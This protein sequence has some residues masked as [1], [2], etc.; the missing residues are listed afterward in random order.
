VTNEN[1]EFWVGIDWA[2]SSH[3][4]CVL[5]SAGRVLEER[6]IDHSCAAIARL[7][8]DLVARAGGNPAKV[9][10]AIE[11]PH[12][13]VVSMLIER[14][15]AVFAINPK[16]LDRFRDRHSVAGAKDDRRDALVL[17]TSLRTDMKSFRRVRLGQA[18]LVQLRELVRVHEDLKH[19]FN[20]LANRLDDLL[21]RFYPQILKLG[22]VHTDPWLWDLLEL[23]P[24]PTQGALLTDASLRDLL[25][26][27]HIRRLNSKVVAEALGEPALQ[28]APG[29]V[30]ACTQHISLL[31][32]RLR[33][34]AQQQRQCLQE[35]RRILAR[36]C[37]PVAQDDDEEADQQRK[38]S[39]AK[40][41]LSLP[42]IGP[43]V[44]ATLLTD[45]S[46]ALID[47]DY[48]SLRAQCGVAPVTRQSGKHKD[49]SIRYACNSRL[50]QATY[51]WARVSTCHDVR[52][53]QHYADLRRKGHSHG[54]ALR[55]IADRLLGLLVAMLK[56]HSLYD[57]TRW[58]QPRASVQPTGQASAVHPPSPSPPHPEPE[59]PAEHPSPSPTRTPTRRA[60]RVSRPPK[61]P[62]AAGP[63]RSAGP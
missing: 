59:P 12:G 48:S 56:T 1:F 9:A 7:V 25:S 50:R 55:G 41:L 34:A 17:G 51:D 28:V 49:V 43:I 54:R 24:T 62:R 33:L 45:A 21:V 39:D 40:I 20:A 31:L 52:N 36:L 16:Q 44:G 11:T 14:G 15:I 2:K 38:H 5:D 3:Q 23:A 46:E 10:A 47:R 29:V 4:V 19:E 58:N 30:E 6:C 60:Q 18:E 26:K 57:P 8:D 53:K 32:P 42:G 22:S 63:E 27:R 13:A 35:M 61:A 37:R